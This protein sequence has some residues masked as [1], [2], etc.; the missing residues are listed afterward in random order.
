MNSPARAKHH[1]GNQHHLHQR[2]REGHLVGV[3]LAG[4]HVL[5]QRL[6]EPGSEE[7]QA[8]QERAHNEPNAARQAPGDRCFPFA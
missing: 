7:S 1:R 6:G 3:E 4:D 5:D 8:S 2:G